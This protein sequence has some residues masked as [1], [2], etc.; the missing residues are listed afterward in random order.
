MTRSDA[1]EAPVEKVNILLVDDQPSR[2]LTYEVILKELGQNLVRAGS[3]SAALARLMKDEYAVILLDVSMPGMDGFETAALIHE[4][5]RF[6]KTPIIFVTAFH[7]TD[8]DRMKGYGLGAVDY[9]YVPVVPEILRG[10]VAV[11]VEL[12]RH[13][14][15]LE[16]VNHRLSSANSDLALANSTLQTEKTRELQRLNRTLERANSELARANATLQAEVAE[17][18]RLEDALREADRRKNEFLAVLGHELRNPLAPILN[19]V[20]VIG[21]KPRKD[22]DL[23][24]CHDVVQ[25][26]VEHLARL[27]DDLLDVARITQGKFKLQTEPFDLATVVAHALETSRPAIESASQDLVV[28]TPREPVRL[29]ADPTRIAQ[30]VSNLLNNAAKYGEPGGRVRL[31]AAAVPARHGDGREIVLSVADTGIG[32]SSEMLPRI[33]EPFMQCAGAQARSNGGLGIGLAL[34]K[35]IAELHGGT[36]EA[37]S[38]GLGRGAEFVV[39][40][41]LVP[42]P[43]PAES[44]RAEDSSSDG[45]GK[46]LRILV[47]DDN[48]ASAK[49]MTML[50]RKMGHEVAT[51][52][53][54]AEAVETA[55]RF[56]PDLA[57]LDIGLPKLDGYEAARRI[58]RLPDGSDVT[59][60]AVTG[61]GQEEDRRRSKDA[62]FDEHLTKP[63][64]HSTLLRV[65]GS[66]SPTVR[67]ETAAHDR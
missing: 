24:W 63:V 27:V 14:R 6:A 36:V 23:R 8:L 12:Y 51:S 48:P 44:G 59:L 4:H 57:F 41:P 9:V 37:A 13:R 46:R 47:V 52:Y 40:F 42:P 1:A 5:P 50:L 18:T 29:V 60:V 22:A 45:G 10:K 31:S 21:M 65:L 2:L 28:E 49:T 30:V 64:G 55:A 17:R 34:V 56:R 15:A 19:A 54:G 66:V 32:V 38:A 20:Q 25:S 35:R 53:D 43:A 39:R 67:R 26:Q 11:F 58:R 7:V 3:G 16:A 62:G 61:W 33:F